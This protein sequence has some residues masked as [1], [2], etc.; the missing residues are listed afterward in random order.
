MVLT[1]V[2]LTVART[3]RDDFG[4]EIWRDMGVDEAPSVFA[5]S[6]VV[7]A[8][9]VTALTAVF[10]WIRH[11]LVAIWITGV[12]MCAALALVAG[13]AAM[14]TMELISPFSFM[15]ACGVGPLLALC[16]VSH[17]D[18]RANCRRI[19][20]AWKSGLFNV[21][22]RYGRILGVW[23]VT[24]YQDFYSNAGRHVALLS[25][26]TLDRFR[27]LDLGLEWSTRLLP[28]PVCEVSSESKSKA[29]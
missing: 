26:D 23:Y 13:S 3:V 15:A 5:L 28:F 21:C 6:E 25:L 4:V 7:V 16:S 18:L 24:R 29:S 11:N 1:Y 12:L 10:I 27:R 14:Q 2:A 17:D 8:I 9:C 20:A 19:E 22:C